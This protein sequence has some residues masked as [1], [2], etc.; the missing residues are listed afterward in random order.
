[1]EAEGDPDHC[2]NRHPIPST[3]STAS[4]FH[5]PSD[6]TTSAWDESHSN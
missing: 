4:S 2:P 3:M 6:S 1:M 5:P